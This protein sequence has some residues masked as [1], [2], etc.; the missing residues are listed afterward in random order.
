MFI[1]VVNICLLLPSLSIPFFGDDFAWLLQSQNPNEFSFLKFICLP[2]PFDY[3][4]PLPKLFFY[5]FSRLPGADFIFFRVA[6]IILHI[7]CA[8]TLYRLSIALKYSK[9]T[10]FA[11]ALIF[12]VLSCHS[13]VL[14]FINCINELFSAF[15]ILA[16]LYLFCEYRSYKN[17]VFIILL[18]LLALLSRESSVCFFP[19][20]LTVNYRSGK[21]KL[22]EV[23]II[24]FIPVVIYLS[25]RIFSETYFGQSNIV[26]IIESLDLNPLK[27]IYKVLHY[28]VNMIFPVK[29]LFEIAGYGTLE[30]LIKAFRKPSENLP[31]F[32]ALSFTVS[33]ISFSVLY[34][35]IRTLKKQMLFPLLFILFSLGIY[36]FSFNTAERFLYLPSAGLSILIALFFEKLSLRR[37]S[38]AV[39][40]VFIIVHSASLVFRSYRHR[41]AAE[42][43]ENVMRDLYNKTTDVKNGSKILFENIPPKQYGIFFLSVFNFQSNWDYNFPER[44]IVFLFSENKKQSDTPDLIYRFIDEK[45]EFE[46]AR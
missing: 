46:K 19:L 5:V 29:M 7:L 37:F 13:E 17:D 24:S 25:F 4:R 34:F 32:I 20:L 12:S 28:F 38:I 15:F 31:V 45:S 35:F 39:F 1:A 23:L 6:V 27:T 2:A 40:L 30:F 9:E 16:G 11:A 8:V 42:Y 41:Q 10:A 18:F 22:R 26:P 44:K 36:L 33:L 14:F 43:S 21:R 3:F